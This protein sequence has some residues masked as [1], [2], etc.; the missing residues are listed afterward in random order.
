MSKLLCELLR[1]LPDSANSSSAFNSTRIYGACIESPPLSN[2]RPIKS[3]ETDTAAIDMQSFLS[4]DFDRLV[5]VR[6]GHTR[7]NNITHIH[8]HPRHQH[9]FPDNIKAG[10]NVMKDYDQ[11]GAAIFVVVVIL[12]YSLSVACMIITN[13]KFKCVLYRR[14][15][16]WFQFRLQ[17]QSDLYETQSEA[18]KDTIQML[19]NQSSKVLTSVAIPASLQVVS[20]EPTALVTTHISSS[21]PSTVKL[22]TESDQLRSA[23]EKTRKSVEFAQTSFI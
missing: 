17:T 16:T 3:V 18:T 19:F 23:K 10:R 4:Q 22:D 9:A 21:P 13:I 15:G 11:S 14:P 8:N 5:A 1:S 20:S 7:H 2:T 12:F 6:D